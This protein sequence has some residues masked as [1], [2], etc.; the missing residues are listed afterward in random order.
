MQVEPRLRGAQR[1]SGSA[2]CLLIGA[3]VASPVSSAIVEC[4]DARGAS[5]LSPAGENS[6][7]SR[8][9]SPRRA[10]DATPA[11]TP[12]S[13]PRVDA[14]LQ[15]QRDNDRQHIL[16]DELRAQTARLTQLE[17]E[18]QRPRAAP[19]AGASALPTADTAELD[20]LLARTRE[21]VRALQR[22]LAGVR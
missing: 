11:A 3:L 5:I 13:F 12:A 4:R 10:V 21:N 7:C 9:P 16:Q 14:S 1:L 8:L 17:R 19:A 20:A 22:E 2:A 6:A 18:T 15:R